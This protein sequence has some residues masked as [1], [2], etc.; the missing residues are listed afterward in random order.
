MF[1]ADYIAAYGYHAILTVGT[2]IF[3]KRR[4]SEESTVQNNMNSTNNQ[5]LQHHKDIDKI[6]N[7]SEMSKQIIRYATFGLGLDDLYNNSL[8]NLLKNKNNSRANV[9]ELK[10]TSVTSTTSSLIPVVVGMLSGLASSI[11][12]YPFDFVRSGVLQPGLKR[13]ISSGSTIPYAGVMFGIYF[14][15]RDPNCTKSQFKWA[16]GSC[17]CSLL[18]EVPFDFA[19]RKMFGSTKLFLGAGFMYVPFAACI[20]LMYDK[21]AIKLTEKFYKR[22]ELDL[23]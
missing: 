6:W 14:S 9:I 11:T 3:I 12:L 22:G 17:S 19:K 8:D 2:L 16:F 10:K 18:A 13:I 21:A 4:A 5:K 20:L 23:Y 15:N 7:F 1:C